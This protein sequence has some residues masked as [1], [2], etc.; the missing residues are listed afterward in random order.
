M[1]PVELSSLAYAKMILH[2]L[3]YP[4][5][6]VFGLLIGKKMEDDGVLCVD[7]IP[8]LHEL[9][10]LTP[11]VEIALASVDNHCSK[12]SVQIV[13]V[14]FCNERLADNGLDSFAVRV[15]EKVLSNFAGAVLVQIENTLLSIDSSLPSTRIYTCDNKAWKSRTFD[16]ENEEGTLAGVSKAI[17]AKLFREIADFEN[18][19]ENTRNDCWNSIINNK[20][21]RMFA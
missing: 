1:R 5:C 17:Q 8:V 9:A 16:I 3:K 13:G 19:L 4:H 6:A 14:Y 15:A 2:A 20:L 10:A 21:K 12:S 7:A 11:A 18:H